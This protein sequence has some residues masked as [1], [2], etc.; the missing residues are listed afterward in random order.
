MQALFRPAASFASS[1]CN[2]AVSASKRGDLQTP[3][4]NALAQLQCYGETP[5]RGFLA[6]LLSIQ[7]TGPESVN[8]A[9]KLSVPPLEEQSP[10]QIALDNEE[11]QELQPV[12]LNLGIACAD[13]SDGVV[14]EICS[15]DQLTADSP[16]LQLDAPLELCLNSPEVDSKFGNPIAIPCPASGGN[17][18]RDPEQLCLGSTTDDHAV[19]VAQPSPVGNSAVG[20]DSF[21]DAIPDD[22]Y[23]QQSLLPADGPGDKSCLAEDLETHMVHGISERGSFP[24]AYSDATAEVA[25]DVSD[26]GSVIDQSQVSRP[27]DRDDASNM[28]EVLDNLSESG[29]SEFSCKI[30]L[31]VSCAS[32]PA[33]TSVA[34]QAAPL[35]D[36]P[37]DVVPPEVTALATAKDI[38]IALPAA[39]PPPCS[40][41]QYPASFTPATSVAAA[42]VV[43]EDKG[44]A[45]Q[46]QW[47]CTQGDP[48][49]ELPFLTPAQR[50]LRMPPETPDMSA[51]VSANSRPTVMGKPWSSGPASVSGPL[52]APMVAEDALEGSTLTFTAV[53][54]ELSSHVAEA[55][56][57][58]TS[59]S[60]ASH[61]LLCSES[62]CESGS[63]G[64]SQSEAKEPCYYT[65]PVIANQLFDQVTPLPR[66]C[67][68]WHGP[69]DK[70]TGS[71]AFVAL[72][73]GCSIMREN[74]LSDP[75]PSRSELPGVVDPLG[76]QHICLDSDAPFE[77]SVYQKC[78]VTHYFSLIYSAF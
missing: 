68:T 18:G 8:P 30:S 43:A 29:G 24:A 46:E 71:S 55:T 34:S 25:C 49:D 2:F 57:H 44:S 64:E 6:N 11:Q 51:Y 48:C 19:A 14:P 23:L 7:L 59:M 38:A 28:G 53:H 35:E 58:E 15:D 73:S 21:P 52:R 67:Y 50:L 45:C 41:D 9:E 56:P 69:I 36:L 26:A 47:Q 5:A 54:K 75:F 60:S 65:Q 12:P 20:F 63:E 22:M 78:K 32:S 66:E 39:T 77:V 72:K 13:S 74:P 3:G 17:E 31:A 62:Q 70:D 16:V 10:H 27:A 1:P 61:S 4:N 37:S 40:Q 76:M 42:E 33:S